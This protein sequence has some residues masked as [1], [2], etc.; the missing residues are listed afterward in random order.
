M[1]QLKKWAKD[2][3]RLFA[4]KKIQMTNKHMTTSGVFG[5]YKSEP[6]WGATSHL[7]M[8]VIKIKQQKVMGVTMAKG[9]IVPS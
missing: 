9:S 3:S 2:L 1:K 6:Q 4:K 8:A 5:K 7:K